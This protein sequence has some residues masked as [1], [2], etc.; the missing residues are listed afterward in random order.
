VKSAQ[1]ELEISAMTSSLLRKLLILSVFG[2]AENPNFS[3]KLY[4]EKG[5]SLEGT[6]GASSVLGK[7][8]V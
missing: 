6:N 3:D 4:E 7:V 2:P 8:Q 5:L 1:Q